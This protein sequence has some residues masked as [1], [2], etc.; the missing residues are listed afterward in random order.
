MLGRKFNVILLSV[1]MVFLYA[2][3]G[4]SADSF[5]LKIVPE[6]LQIGTFFAGKTATLFGSISANQNLL[7]EIIGP[8]ENARFYLKG[9]VGPFWMNREKVELEQVP[10]LYQLLL[11]GHQRE[12]KRWHA[13][14]VG[15]QNLR[16]RITV[17]PARL[18]G[19][20][21]FNQ[22]TKLKRSQDLY[23]EQNGA[24]RYSPIR[25]DQKAFEATFYFPSSTVPGE[26]QIIA[27]RLQG[28]V[29]IKRSVYDYKVKEVGIIQKIGELA[30]HKELIYGILC[31]VIALFVGAVIGL[32]F[33]HT[34][35]H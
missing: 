16:Q 2:H 23:G 7:I 4:I 31:V 13:L 15:L 32:F 27:S 12:E 25:Q 19:D 10:F 9:R 8:Q 29:I 17:K 3:S 11:P 28:K 14:N 26:Y 18:N 35:A 34:E 6:N 1:G 30:Y 20:M 22:L 33:K 24:I 21:I 5:T